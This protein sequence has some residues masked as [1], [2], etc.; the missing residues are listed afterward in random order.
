MVRWDMDLKVMVLGAMWNGI[1]VEQ[2]QDRLLWYLV[3][4][5]LEGC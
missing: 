2:S 4:T 1:G 5:G 3:L